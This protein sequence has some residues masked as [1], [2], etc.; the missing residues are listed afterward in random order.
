MTAKPEGRPDRPSSSRKRKPSRRAVHDGDLTE[1]GAAF[2]AA[3]AEHGN[4]TR[5]AI[6]AGYPEHTAHQAGYAL[7]R[8][9][10]IRSAVSES[11]M[12]I[13]D[14]LRLSADGLIARARGSRPGSD[15]K[16]ALARDSLCEPRS[17]PRSA[18]A[19]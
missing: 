18:P 9:P 1:V 8:K 3:Y 6:A 7:L 4:T 12:L 16:G 17:A 14:R 13:A 11:K 5:A 10:E 2:V 19:T 15:P